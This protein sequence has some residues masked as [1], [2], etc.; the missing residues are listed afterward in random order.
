VRVDDG[1]FHKWPDLNIDCGYRAHAADASSLHG[2][3]TAKIAPV[4]AKL[5][6]VV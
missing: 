6:H 4:G 5:P 2:I 3:A 1:I